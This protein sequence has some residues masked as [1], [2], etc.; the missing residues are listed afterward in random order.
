[1]Y[2][3]GVLFLAAVVIVAAI[4]MI[5]EKDKG[6]EYHS[7]MLLLQS[8]MGTVSQKVNSCLSSVEKT[9]E[10]NDLIKTE[11]QKLLKER[12]EEN[13]HFCDEINAL[14]EHC[15][16]LRSEL[17]TLRNEVASKRP[18]LDVQGPIPIEIYTPPKN[19]GKDLESAKKLN[20][21]SIYEKS[22][23]KKVRTKK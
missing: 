20:K 9:V 21:N 14:Q 19:L 2:E 16:G 15:A 11:F 7:G 13:E 1:M 23:A 17:L 5:L 12:K 10:A 22:G 8:Q 18:L 4:V 3:Y 6:K